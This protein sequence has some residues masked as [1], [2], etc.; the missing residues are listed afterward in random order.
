MPL[1]IYVDFD[2]VLC[3]TANPLSLLANRLYGCTVGY[4][5]IHTFDL[6]EAFALDEARYQ[7]LMSVAHE[8]GHLLN[9][10]ATPGA[11]ATLAAWAQC[12]HAVEI[13]T[14]RP[15]ATHA[16]SVAWL[17]RHGLSQI[18]IIHVDKYN[19]EPAPVTDDGARALTVEEFSR[20]R[21][22]LAI[23]DAPVALAQLAKMPPCK[24]VIFD[25]PWN[26]I[27]PG[28]TAQFTRCPDWREVER[29]VAHGLLEL[30]ES[31]STSNRRSAVTRAR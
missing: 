13:V 4:A 22:D 27:L 25:R 17:A 31:H 1:R 28:V 6:R 5:D 15:F 12:G 7:R 9:L 14:G 16:I 29:F 21:Y 20:K 2:D 19:R 11:V 26:R 30:P 8:P 23:E 18:P 24:V 10:E 3:E